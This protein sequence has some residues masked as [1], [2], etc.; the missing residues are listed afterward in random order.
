MHAFAAPA[1]LLIAVACSAIAPAWRGSLLLVGGGL[2][3]DAAA[4]HAEL[5]RPAPN[6]ARRVIVATAATGQQAVEATDKSEALRCFAPDIAIDVVQRETSASATIA[7]FDGATAA[8]FTGGD[9]KRITTRYRPD[10]IDGDELAAMRRLVERGGTL[11][12]GSAGCAMLGERMLLGGSSALA[13]GIAPPPGDGEPP[14]LGPRVGPGMGFLAGVLTDSHFFERD[15]IGRLVAALVQ[16]PD[17]FGLGVGED[18]ALLIDPIARTALGLTVAESLWVDATFARRD[19]KRWLGLRAKLIGE[20]ELLPLRPLGSTPPPAL[21]AALTNAVDVPVV[22]PGQNR[23]LASWRL[24]K[25][26]AQPN[27]PPRRLVLDGF[28]VVA[29]PEIGNAD[30]SGDRHARSG[31]VVF[32]V[33][34]AD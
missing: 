3:D 24:F 7:A 2:D 1:L 22:E 23:Q 14:Q 31:V 25:H 27:S 26:A 30:G 34:I 12:G 16:G 21:P 5:L 6:G 18:A 9:Q 28:E 13:L 32:E 4:V 8:F 17:R 10:G 19:G 20:R 33:R 15:R 11:G 29:T